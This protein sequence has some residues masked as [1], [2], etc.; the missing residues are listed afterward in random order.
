M[1][2]ELCET[3][4]GELFWEDRHCRVVLVDE[5]D[6]PGFCR[7]VWDAHVKEMSDL[8][9]ADRGHLM[10]VVFAVEEAVRRVMNP[11]KINLA[12]LGNLTPHLHWHVIPRFEHDRHFP[13]PVWCEPKRE[14]SAEQASENYRQRLKD[15]VQYSCSSVIR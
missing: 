3:I 4:G 10:G 2:C 11:D 5:P 6:Y 15:A 7:V 8:V 12:S 1:A 9:E 13:M 14:R